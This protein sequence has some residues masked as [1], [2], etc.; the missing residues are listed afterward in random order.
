MVQQYGD[1]K[2]PMKR[3]HNIQDDFEAV[4]RIY[5]AAEGGRIAP[6]YNGI[7]WDFAYADDPP[8]SQLYMI[9]PDFYDQ[10]GDSLPI[11]Q[12]LALS[13]ELPARMVVIVDKMRAEL[14]RSRIAPGIR[15]YCYEGRKPVAEG[16]VTRIT[17]LFDQRPNFKGTDCKS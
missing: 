10:Q 5:T 13:I 7:R 3:L 11:D 6:I 1:F 14:H 4:I 8:A 9:H 2:S 16:R 12:P 15:F 17:G